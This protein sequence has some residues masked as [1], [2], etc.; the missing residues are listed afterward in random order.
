MCCHRSD[1]DVHRRHQEELQAMETQM[2]ER[3]LHYEDQIQTLLKQLEN[4]L[5]TSPFRPDG[6]SQ[7]SRMAV[8]PAHSSASSASSSSSS[9]KAHRMA[10]LLSVAVNGEE[11][12]ASSSVDN[13]LPLV[14]NR[15]MGQWHDVS[16]YSFKKYQGDTTVLVSQWRKKC[17]RYLFNFLVYLLA[18]L[19][20]IQQTVMSLFRLKKTQLK[21]E[22]IL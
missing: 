4:L 21:Y 6:Q 2:Q 7:E 10:A 11:A 1:E 18:N 8:S 15:D 22:I 9:R 17:K 3:A 12:P 5:Q 13:F 20:K 16:I 19:I 14:S